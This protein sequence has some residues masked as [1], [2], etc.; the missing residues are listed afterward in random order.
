MR[1]SP[2]TGESGFALLDMLVGLA[3]L[4]LLL[5]ALVTAVSFV[6]RQQ[7]VLKAREETRE[8]VLAAARLMRSL[9]DGAPAP[10]ERNR[11]IDLSGSDRAFIIR[12]IGPAV[13]ALQEPS[14]FQIAADLNAG[15]GN[16]VVSWKD[17]QSN[18]ERRRSI[19]GGLKQASF[20]YLVQDGRQTEK[21]WRSSVSAETGQVQAVRLTLLPIEHG[22]AIEIVTPVRSK[23]PALCANLQAGRTCRAQTP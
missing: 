8:S 15:G 14:V 5:S 21:Q 17:P 20:D 4:G 10:L 6:T 19:A 1:A 22:S 12:S 3:V 13:L 9:I 11:G 23:I 18:G 2:R 7:G 16:L